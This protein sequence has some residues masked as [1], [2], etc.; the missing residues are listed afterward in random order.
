LVAVPAFP[1]QVFLCHFHWMFQCLV[2]LVQAG[3]SGE[4]EGQGRGASQE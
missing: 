3:H 4:G 2:H 1:L